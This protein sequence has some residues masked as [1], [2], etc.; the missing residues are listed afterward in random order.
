MIHMKYIVYIICICIQS[1]LQLQ[2]KVQMNTVK[3]IMQ[4]IFI[5]TKNKTSQYTR[6]RDIKNYTTDLFSYWKSILDFPVI[7]SAS[8]RFM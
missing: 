8:L 1:V 4:M 7:R 3:Y 5:I 2:G 6:G